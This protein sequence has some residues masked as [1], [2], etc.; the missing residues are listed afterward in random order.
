MI[1]EPTGGG[2]QEMDAIG[3][4]GLLDVHREAA[5]DGKRRNFEIPGNAIDLIHILQRQLPGGYQDQGLGDATGGIN[6]LHQRDA[7]GAGLAG[8]GFRH[9]QQVAAFED[10]G[11]S[12]FLHRGEFDKPHPVEGLQD[13]R[14]QRQFGKF[15]DSSQ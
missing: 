6:I 1:D 11:K 10:G 15:H 2:N 7:A 9:G 12:L 4:F 13:F 3:Q 5:V 14:L 8:T